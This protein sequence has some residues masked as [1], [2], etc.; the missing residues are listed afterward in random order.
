MFVLLLSLIVHVN[1]FS[2][3]IMQCDQVDIEGIAEMS[4][5]DC[6]FSLKQSMEVLLFLLKILH[7]Q[8]AGKYLI[9][10]TA[11]ADEVTILESTTVCHSDS[12]DDMFD[13]W[14]SL[15]GG[16]DPHHES[17][18]LN[19]AIAWLPVTVH[20]QSPHHKRHNLIPATFPPK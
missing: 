19:S 15:V 12:S 9:C 4:K 11:G 2:N 18:G 7:R 14:L 3:E 10:H 6:C 17:V 16:F 5:K 20:K 13:L 1:G 8:T